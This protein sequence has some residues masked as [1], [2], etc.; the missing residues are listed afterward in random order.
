[1]ESYPTGLSWDGASPVKS[2]AFVVAALLELVR[3]ILVHLP[4]S[5]IDLHGGEQGLLLSGAVAQGI[6]AIGAEQPIRSVTSQLAELA[7][8]I[9]R[10]TRALSTRVLFGGE[11]QGITPLLAG[12]AGM[13]QGILRVGEHA[14]PSQLVIKPR[15]GDVHERIAQAGAV[16]LGK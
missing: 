11:K 4:E 8:G 13:R 14:G 10:L 6:E 16:D 9:E 15:Q 1:L 3:E 12:Q 2:G 7:Q 5:G